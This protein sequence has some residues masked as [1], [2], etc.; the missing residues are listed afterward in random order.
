MWKGFLALLKKDFKLMLSSKFLLLALGSLILYSCYINFIYVGLDQ[1]IYPVYLYDPLHTQRVISSEIISV[2]NLEEL[3]IKSGD[4]Y[5]VGIYASSGTPKIIMVSSGVRSTDQYRAAYALSLLSPSTSAKAEIIGEN[6]KELKNRRE[7]TCEFLFFELTAVGFLG[8]A[9]MLFKEKQMGIIRVHGILPVSKTAFII[10]KLCLFLIADI[11]FAILLT[12]I[13]LGVSV[14][15]LTLPAVVLQAGILSLIMA[16]VGFFCA[17]LLPDFKQFS[18]LYLVLAVFITTPVFLAGQ[19]G[20]AWDFIKYHP[21][22]H[23]FMAIKNAYFNTP[24]VNG[25]YYTICGLA[26]VLLF[27]LVRRMLI[28][29]MAKEG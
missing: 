14:G 29:E 24:S 21:M 19:T 2:D 11:V 22:Y 23:L 13:N 25:I 10:S 17:V 1:E 27:L 18:L 7:I 26:I 12:V 5:A 15:L 6:N 28:R 3:Q 4:G 8:L 20:I 9:S 16:L